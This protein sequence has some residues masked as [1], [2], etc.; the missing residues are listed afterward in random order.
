MM[1]RKTNIGEQC[2]EKSNTNLDNQNSFIKCYFFK[3]CMCVSML[4]ISV[5]VR[6]KKYPKHDLHIFY[7]Y[8]ASSKVVQQLHF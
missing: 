4:K 3:K 6:I 1:L 2:L 8:L 7:I 5:L